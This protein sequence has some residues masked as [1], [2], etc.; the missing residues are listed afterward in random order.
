MMLPLAVTSV[1][2]HTVTQGLSLA[3]ASQRGR[4]I[5][6]SVLLLSSQEPLHDAC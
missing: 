1:T 2:Y 3:T 4:K 6:P 5:S